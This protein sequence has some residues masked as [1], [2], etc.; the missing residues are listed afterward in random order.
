MKYFIT[1][2]FLVGCLTAFAQNPIDGEW[3]GT[4]ETPNGAFEI[5]YTYKVDGDVLTGVW[6]TQ[7]GEASIENGKVDGKKFSYTVSFN[8]MTI[9]NTGELVTSDEIMI[10]NERGEMKLTRVK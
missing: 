1:A 3:K 8:E 4:R 7:F 2:A 5:N 9:N 6:K 10:K